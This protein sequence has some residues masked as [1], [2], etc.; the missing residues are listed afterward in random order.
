[1]PTSGEFMIFRILG[2]EI[3]KLPNC[4]LSIARVAALIYCCGHNSYPMKF[5]LLCAIGAASVF[6]AHCAPQSWP[7]F[8]GPNSSGVSA[9]AKPPVKIGPTNNVAWK[10][11]VPWSP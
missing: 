7:A 5:L 2:H 10:T 6:E 9:D 8:R 3:R 11:E 1:M 4:H